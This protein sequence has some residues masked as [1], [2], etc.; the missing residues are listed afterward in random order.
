MHMTAPN[1]SPL[2]AAIRRLMPS[3]PRQVRT[4]LSAP[5]W[6]YPPLLA[7]KVSVGGVALAPYFD[8]CPLS[9]D[10][11]RAVWEEYIHHYVA[12]VETPNMTPRDYLINKLGLHSK[13]SRWLIPVRGEASHHLAA[14][15]AILANKTNLTVDFSKGAVLKHKNFQIGVTEG[16]AVLSRFHPE[17][18]V[19]ELDWRSVLCNSS[20][21]SLQSS[22][23]VSLSAYYR[24]AGW[25]TDPTEREVVR[26]A[27][28]VLYFRYGHL[29]RLTS[30]LF[31]G[32]ATRV[33]KVSPLKRVASSILTMNNPIPFLWQEL[34]VGGLI[35]EAE[36]NSYFPHTKE[37][38]DANSAGFVP[39][40]T[41]A[42]WVSIIKTLEE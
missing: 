42:D 10:E 14:L 21:S 2:V 28:R 15:L 27:L 13:L 34:V 37:M 22:R 7:P 4:R 38:R 17:A 24:E 25:I 36:F 19:A 30:Y 40:D 18:K 29:G 16:G 31:D 26:L 39:T 41:V 9:I 33:P 5:E 6:P 12:G 8:V 20:A 32:M 3:I 23:C 11:V 1:I 35:T